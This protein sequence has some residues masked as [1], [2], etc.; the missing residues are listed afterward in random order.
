MET[1][2]EHTIAQRP[3]D[4]S[5]GSPGRL[6][7]GVPEVS[8]SLQELEYMAL[9]SNPTLSQA[10]M[11]IRSAQGGYL[12]A[13]LYPNPVAGYIADDMG[14]DGRAG[15]Q[16]M[17]LA[18]EIVTTHKLRLGQGVAS[19]EI[20]RAR[21]GL[22]K[23][24][25]SVLNA[26]RI[27]YYETL[28]AQRAVEVYEKLLDISNEGIRVTEKLG[29]AKEVSQADVLQA[30]IE[31]EETQLNLNKARHLY[32]TAWGRLSATIGYPNMAATPLVGDIE[33][34]LPNL[35][36]NDLL[37][38]IL[39]GS[40][41]LAAAR[42]AVNRARCNVALQCA[43]RTPNF[44]ISTAVKRD[45]GSEY[46]IADFGFAM[47]IPI[48]NRNQGNIVAAQAELTSAVREVRRIELDLHA[49]FI[50][51]F[52]EYALARQHVHSYTDTILPNAK[53][54]LE[55]NSIG[56]REG[57]F[58]YLMLLTAQRTYFSANLE[59]LINLG[60]LW[61]KSV[62]LE[63]MLLSGGGLERPE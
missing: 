27:G 4:S 11:V 62:E 30:R 13:G 56:Y 22:T 49:R 51:A 15:V 37:N 16:G 41:E 19:Y 63:G 39:E 31:A 10:R 47:P 28:V 3:N 17:G 44:E 18:Q 21:F 24:Q 14:N 54:S 2:P 59:Y 29:A 38:R 25:Y 52:E 42:A 12:Q 32:R 33:K 35:E 5:L 55:M 45:Y 50:A 58:D 60:E 8:L 53:K 9:Q 23:Q 57:E 43:E 61:T 40:P 46:T 36:Q 6:Q 20:Q 7:S 48:Y 1:W 26:V 34:N